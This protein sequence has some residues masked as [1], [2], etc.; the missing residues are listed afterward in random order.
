MNI[1]NN[2]IDFK[3]KCIYDYVNILVNKIKNEFSK[4]VVDEFIS[5]YIQTYYFHH[6]QTLENIDNYD[7]KV[8]LDEFEGKE[9]EIIYELDSNIDKQ[10]ATTLTKKL[11]NIVLLSIKID[12]LNKNLKKEELK[13]ELKTILSN[14]K[15][16]EVII[17]ELVKQI[18]LNNT[19]ENKFLKTIELE[20]FKLEYNLYK[21]Q[22]NKYQVKLKNN[23]KQLKSNYNEKS[24]VKNFDSEK[25]G[26]KKFLITINLLNIEILYKIMNSEEIDYYF[27][28]IPG[29]LLDDK[30]EIIKILNTIDNPYIN[31]H[32]VFLLN[33]NYYLNHK[34]ILNL[35]D[36]K[37]SFAAYLDISH[38]RNVEEKIEDVESIKI[39]DYVVIDKIKNKD[40]ELVCK[41]ES[42]TGKEIFI[43]EID[44][45]E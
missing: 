36:I 42:V 37:Y 8:I 12:K 6:L 25:L 4:K 28:E 21:N 23:I 33:Y 22:N 15:I 30:E 9:L 38:I 10:K 19:K 26:K 29:Y 44:N 13:E 41:Y 24:I 20:D 3:K 16:E 1:L 31:N 7:F 14:Y 40:Y 18:I 39:F 11:K 5:T 34:K 32:I 2:Y 27:I 43:N 35:I 45:G 17:E